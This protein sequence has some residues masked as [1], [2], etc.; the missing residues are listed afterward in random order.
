[1]RKQYTSAG[2]DVIFDC[3]HS[4][5]RVIRL[6]ITVCKA[7]ND[8][9]KIIQIIMI[10]IIPSLVF[11]GINRRKGNVKDIVHFFNILSE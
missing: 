9:I 7:Y 5:C 11:I 8:H 10:E 3:S 2:L 6:H 1:M 4:T